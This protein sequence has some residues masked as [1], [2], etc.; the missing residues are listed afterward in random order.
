MEIMDALK[1][2]TESIH[3]WT[4]DNL[5]NKVDKIAGKSLSTNDYTAADKQAVDSI[6]TGLTVLDG[7]LYLSKD[8]ELL[9]S[10]VTLPSGGGGG[11]SSSSASITLE[12]ELES[13]TITAAVNS[14]ILLKFNY[15]SS[16]DET[17]NG[18]AYV[19]VNDVLKTTTVISSGSNTIN[20]GEFVGEGI[21]AVKLTCMD[22]YSNS[23]SLS[24]S[25][26]I[27]S[28]KITSTF[29]DS[30]IFDGDINIRYIPYGATSKNIHLSIDGKDTII[31]V[32]SETS[33]QQSYIIDGSSISHG[34]HDL[35]LYLSA[36]VNGVQIISNKLY[37]SIVK[38]EAGI[39]TPIISS[40]CTTESITQGEQVQVTYVVYDPVN[41]STDIS[42]IIHQNN[43]IYSS[44]TRT[45]DAT[46]QMWITSDLPV[47]NVTLTL[48]YGTIERSH[49]ITVLE[50]DIDVSIKT[51]DLEFE[52]KAAGR[53]NEDVDRDIWENNGITT[54]FERINYQSTGWVTDNN[55]DTALRLSGSAK[56]TINFMPFKSDS[57]STGRTL[58]F[59][60]AIRDVNNK[61]AIA[62][63]CFNSNIGFQ[64]KADTAIMRSEQTLVSCNYT[65]EEKIH[66]AFV[67][68]PRTEYRLM[69]VYLNGVLSGVKQY[70]ENDNFQQGSD[71]VNIE[72]GSPYCSI[73]IY[74]IRSYNTALTADEIKGNYIASITDIS[75]QLSIYEDNNI[76]DIYGNLSFDKLKDKIPILVITGNSLPTYKGDKKKVSISFTH[77]EKPSLNYEDTATI[78]IQGTSSQFYIRKNW[79]IKMSNYHMIDTD[80]IETK[81]ICTKADYAESTGSHNTA[82]ANYVHTLYGDSKVL[83]QISDERVRTTIY[84]YPIAIFY[85]TDAAATPE[86]VGRD[87]C[88]H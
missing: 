9:S 72:I 41:L 61:N 45:V 21:N 32:T 58:E 29:D 48:K 80:K 74:A 34:V 67:I 40:V 19:Y 75:K 66:V 23:K 53:S 49:N 28:L 55:G 8:G 35:V 11:G 78:D 79:K 81:V 64:I 71:S 44:I 12:N 82:G 51:T 3:S 42:L 56:A 59:E 37:Y 86:F 18:T 88:P 47:G 46:K 17:G 31:A 4:D 2:V 1:K 60:Y 69:S 25:I 65:D 30:Q 57:R 16:E 83:P 38:T 52:L 6:A 15:L 70:P 76:Y 27:I 26:N 63:S 68:E 62:I 33:K 14:D 85:K 77:P 73:D 43:E 84:G 22:K 20:I 24:Y 87:I 10:G 5:K 7:K 54:T 50:N 13:A 39:T 36:E